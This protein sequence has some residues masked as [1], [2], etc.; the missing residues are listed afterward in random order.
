MAASLVGGQIGSLLL[1]RPAISFLWQS[2]RALGKIGLSL[3]LEEFLGAFPLSFLGAFR[4]GSLPLFG[5]RFALWFFLCG[6]K[7][8]LAKTTPWS[9]TIQ[10]GPA[11]LFSLWEADP[12]F[13]PEVHLTKPSRRTVAP[14]T[15]AD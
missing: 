1:S 7:T 2:F 14:L 13:A 10:I 11:R 5:E 6:K 4:T 3:L 12:I 8:L 9:R 15:E